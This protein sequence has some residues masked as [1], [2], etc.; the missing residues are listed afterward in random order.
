MLT[1]VDI[2]GVK[3][4]QQNARRHEGLLRTALHLT[5]VGGWEWDIAKQTLFWTEDLYRIHE[6]EPEDLVAGS[7]DHIARSLAGYAPEDQPAVRAAFQKCIAD[8]TPYDLE[9][10]FTTAKGRPLRIRTRAEPVREHGRVIRVLGTLL[11][12]TDRLPADAAADA[13]AVAT[14]R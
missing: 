10:R 5:R 9:C 1:F 4:A 8:G 11:D 14:T 7:P 12:I 13:P 2:S 3:L 6:L